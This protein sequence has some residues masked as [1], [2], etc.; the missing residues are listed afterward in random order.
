MSQNQSP[1]NL[2]PESSSTAQ[3]IRSSINDSLTGKLSRRAE[4]RVF[5]EISLNGELSLADLQRLISEPGIIN[6]D[7]LLGELQRLDLDPEELASLQSIANSIVGQFADN[8]PLAPIIPEEYQFLSRMS[9]S[10]V[11]RA[12]QILVLIAFLSLS[13]IDKAEAASLVPTPTATSMAT[14]E[15][16]PKP[17]TTVK[18]VNIPTIMPTPEVTATAE[19]TPT[20]E[21]KILIVETREVNTT[22]NIRSG[23]GTNFPIVDSL[24]AGET[25]TVTQNLG[26]WLKIS[27]VDPQTN[28][29]VGSGDDQRY[30]FVSL[31]SEPK[32]QRIVI[33]ITAIEGNVG[34]TSTVPITSTGT[35]TNPVRAEGVGGLISDEELLNQAKEHFSQ[36]GLLIITLGYDLPIAV[37]KDAKLVG[38]F[39]NSNWEDFNST[40]LDSE[41]VLAV[42]Q[43]ILPNAVELS[44][45]E[46]SSLVLDQNGNM[47]AR[48]EK[49]SIFLIQIEQLLTFLKERT[50]ALTDLNLISQKIIA[51]KLEDGI[52]TVII[53]EYKF[54]FLAKQWLL[55]PNT[56]PAGEEPTTAEEIEASVE[57]SPLLISM[58]EDYDYNGTLKLTEEASKIFYEWFLRAFSKSP[59]LSPIMGTTPEEVEAYLVNHDYQLPV[60][61]QL[62]YQLPRIVESISTHDRVTY[63]SP[64]SPIILKNVEVQLIW[65]NETSKFKEIQDRIIWSGNQPGDSG[66]A[67][68]VK[69][70]GTLVITKIIMKDPILLSDLNILLE[71]TSKGVWIGLG[72]IELYQGKNLSGQDE[73]NFINS[74]QVARSLKNSFKLNPFLTIN[75]SR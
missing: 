74:R 7:Q 57:E 72:M 40:T 45:R 31:T 66:T 2:S 10:L 6:P 29:E 61:F 52:Q 4:Q 15:P 28:K 42:I 39:K 36:E 5:G 70:D 22:S 64:K 20:P 13:V 17:T 27:Y 3:S 65:N 33:P 73:M 38:F 14:G 54:Q 34:V 32:L 62:P 30:I 25:I 67:L 56:P 49:Q 41:N 43:N 71:E 55:V 21:T 11:A 1:E 16:T 47:L 23:P 63:K 44:L 35:I 51:I 9:E 59:K 69:E 26:D 58:E 8:Q 48:I 19:V 12:L 24:V 68:W 46:E 37:D 18:P 60:E 50:T 53:G 75:Q